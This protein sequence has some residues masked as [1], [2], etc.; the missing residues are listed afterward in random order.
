MIAFH[1]YLWSW[2]S[3]LG[4]IL[5]PP[6]ARGSGRYLPGAMRIHSV[7]PILTLTDSHYMN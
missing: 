7:H 5:D 1:I 2:R 4:E 6:L 3:Y